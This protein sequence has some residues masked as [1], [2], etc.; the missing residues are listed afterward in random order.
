MTNMK[1]SNLRQ[2]KII[3]YA[4]SISSLFPIM[5]FF[6]SQNVLWK[7]I[8]LLLS[9]VL[10]LI[11]LNLRG[12]EIENSGECFS[13]KKMHPF[14]KKRYVPSKIEFPISAIYQLDILE[15]LFV[16]HMNIKI[17]THHSK[18]NLRISLPLFTRHQI[19]NIRNLLEMRMCH[20]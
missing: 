14:A 13:L 7:F 9:V 20:A 6:A 8:F 11:V 17:Q 1:I 18:K 16:N 2:V 10:I 19:L 12:I 15:G 3:G 5:G 4:I